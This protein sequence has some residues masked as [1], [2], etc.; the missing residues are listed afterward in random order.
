M[1]V[2]LAD[3]KTRSLLRAD[4]PLETQRYETG[5]VEE[6]INE[7]LAELYDLLV[8]KEGYDRFLDS[9]SAA[10]VS[11]QK[12][13]DLP[14]AFF[15]SAGLDIQ[16]PADS[17]YYTLLQYSH[18]DRMLYQNSTEF[19]VDGIPRYRYRIVK[20]YFEILPEPAGAYNFTLH[21]VPQL[22]K[23]VNTTDAVQDEIVE[24]WLEYVVVDVA[25]KLLDLDEE[26]EKATLMRQTKGALAGRIAGASG[27][28]LEV[29]DVVADS[30]NSLF[31]L[32]TE[33]RY[34]ANM[35]GLAGKLVTDRE[36][37][38]YINRSLEELYDLVIQA[39]DAN[40][41]LDGYD[42]TLVP[43]QEDYNL[44]TD[45]YKFGGL[46][47]VI[48]GETFALGNFNF[49]ER[50]YYDSSITAG[51]WDTPLMHYNVQ[52]TTIKILPTPRT[53]YECKAWYTKLPVALA[54]DSDTVDDAVIRSWLEYVTTDAAIKMLN[55][56]LLS[57]APT[58]VA[59]ISAALQNL[60][61]QKGALKQRLTVMIENRN[62]GQAEKMVDSGWND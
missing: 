36:L 58:K 26:T 39:Y 18:A 22:T 46:D 20:D 16:A 38:T 54:A 14:T 32:R 13:Y 2:T 10:T 52:S 53:T 59:A 3:L 30:A 31:N 62:W 12:R 41:F 37:T 40:Y 7:S 24:S 8:I 55:K 56:G 51:R 33:A 34:K 44:P 35:V 4:M 48:G 27:R 57:A 25:I 17:R 23:L 5:Q 29:A 42:F 61:G 21:Y 6:Y 1:A 60:A 11:G 28:D 15:K 19:I 49:A 47:V 9:Y 50:A 43:D 45:F